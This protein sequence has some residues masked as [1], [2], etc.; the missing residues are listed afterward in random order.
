MFAAAEE[1]TLS[2]SGSSL[3]SFLRP[4]R[5]HGSGSYPRG[6]TQQGS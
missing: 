4:W 5:P 6:T 3:T 1:L 2:L